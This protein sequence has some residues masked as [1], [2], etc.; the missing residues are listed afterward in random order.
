MINSQKVYKKLQNQVLNNG[1][2]VIKKNDAI[3][4]AKGKLFLEIIESVPPKLKQ[5]NAEVPLDTIYD[6]GYHKKSKALF[7]CNKG[8]YL[9]ARAPKSEK[10]YGSAH[11]GFSIYM[12]KHGVEIADVGITG[13]IT[14]GDFIVLRPESACAPSFIV[15]SQRCNCH[16]Q[17][18][19]VREL[20]AYH[21][22]IKLPKTSNP[23]KFEE[24][25]AGYF[26]ANDKNVP[27]PKDK[28]RGFIFIHMA[29]QNGMGSGADENS[30]VEDMTAT[31]YMRHRGEYT[32]EQVHDV[33]LAGGFTALGLTPDP[34][35][36][37]DNAG[38]KIPAVILDYFDIQKPIIALTNNRDKI[39]ILNDMGFYVSRIQFI[40]RSDIACGVET[41]D[42]REE[43]L[44]NIPE[45]FKTSLEEDL[46]RVD[47]EI[48]KAFKNHHKKLKYSNKLSK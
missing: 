48:H 5:K 26:K 24:Y 22:P 34:R 41:E 45:G 12:P 15:G 10:Y 40:G 43:F 36:L 29:S 28:G 37:N 14:K 1:S 39:K 13:D 17:W 27:I 20:A 11:M 2:D 8:A 3:Y 25:V 6:A 23:D 7:V 35:K 32:A 31:A 38:Y 44:H 9:L 30:F 4:L 46:K 33:S 18:V 16:D 19:L 42:R 21:N 47:K